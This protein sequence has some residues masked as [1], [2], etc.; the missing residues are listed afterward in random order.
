MVPA[1]ASSL[2][3][4][5]P[6]RDWLFAAVLAAGLN[7]C[8]FSLMPG[9]VRPVTQGPG[10]ADP[11]EQIRVVRVKR[12]EQ[13]PKKKQPEKVIQARPEQAR[14]PRQPLPKPVPARPRLALPNLTLSTP[15]LPEA[16]LDIQAP[17]LK[18][19]ALEVPALKAAYEIGELDGGLTPLSTLQPD[20]PFRAKRRGIEGHVT[21]EFLVTARGRVEEVTILEAEPENI[22]NQAV[23]NALR[24]WRFQPPTVEGVKV[25]ARARTTFHFKL[26][27]D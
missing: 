14:V 20:Y 16:R 8:L 26:E 3:L 22:F 15:V 21:V 4:Q 1:K 9:L 12:V 24:L 18:G 10:P 23:E 19:P 5:G 27:G 13:P 17:L 7:I 6:F 2:T 11:L 25:A